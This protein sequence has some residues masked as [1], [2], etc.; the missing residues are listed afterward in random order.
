MLGTTGLLAVEVEQ[1][2]T[3]DMLVGQAEMAGT[4]AEAALAD[5]AAEEVAQA[6]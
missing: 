1:A 6:L 3:V 2:D 5:K 4:A